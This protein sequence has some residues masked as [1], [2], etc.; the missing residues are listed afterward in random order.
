MNRKKTIFIVPGYKHT[1]AQKAYRELAKRLKQEGYAPILVRI[2]WRRT[3]I[4]ENTEIF[5]KEFKKLKGKQK[6]ILGFSYGAMIAFLASTK[7]RVSG[8][9]LCSLSPYFQEDMKGMHSNSVSTIMKQRL[10]D[11]KQLRCGRLAKHVKTKQVLLFYG[12][13]ESKSLIRRVE[14]AYK[15][16]KTKE[17]YLIQIQ[18][19]D[20][21]ISDKKYLSTVHHMTSALL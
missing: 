13:D 19:V 15:Q 20:H 12:A 1:P 16:I 11:F 21:D 9:V 5:L 10:D 3:T 18:K 8:L 2:P 14:S 17:K 7:V 4:S 6:Y